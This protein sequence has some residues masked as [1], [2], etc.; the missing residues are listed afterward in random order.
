MQTIGASGEMRLTIDSHSLTIC[1]HGASMSHP[2]AIMK[3]PITD[4]SMLRAMQYLVAR[5]CQYSGLR[6]CTRNITAVRAED[7]AMR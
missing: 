4:V 6:V 3:N 1:D 2:N 5:V 7:V